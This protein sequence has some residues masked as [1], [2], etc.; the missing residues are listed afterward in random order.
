M[1]LIELIW[2]L[3]IFLGIFA[4]FEIAPFDIA[5]NAV[6]LSLAILSLV[7]IHIARTSLSR[8]SSLRRFA[9]Y[10]FYCMIFM[11][12]FS[13]ASLFSL[14]FTLPRFLGQVLL[15]IAYMLLIVSSYKL[16][17]IGTEFGFS[18]QS[19]DIQRI[20]KLKKLNDAGKKRTNRTS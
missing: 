7:W 4:I 14:I 2:I 11:F 18:V 5:V 12:L 8:G 16:M 1:K 6:I 10:V 17:R 9:S 3:G 19:R 15:A 20:I 13:A